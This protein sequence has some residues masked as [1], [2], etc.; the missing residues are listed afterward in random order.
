MYG[1]FAGVPMYRIIGSDGIERGPVTAEQIRQWLAEGRIGTGARVLAEG[2]EEWRPLSVFPE[3]MGMVGSMPD[4]SAAD[5]VKGPAIGLLVTAIVGIAI[6]VLSI[7]LNFL[8]VGVGLQEQAAPDA[9]MNVLSGTI[10]IVFSFI[11]I[12]IGAVILIGAQ[13]MKRLESYNWAMAAS[14]I[15]LVPCISPCC[16]LGLPFGIWALIVLGQPNMKNAFQH[17]GNL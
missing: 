3:L 10:G 5:K 13:K 4:P 7:L 11:G 1:D 9:F 12:G 16:I 14:I 15:A 17:P 8:G 6:Q 2:S